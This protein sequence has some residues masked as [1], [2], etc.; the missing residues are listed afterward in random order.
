LDIG[1]GL[2]IPRLQ[3]GF[4]IKAAMELGMRVGPSQDLFELADLQVPQGL[5][6]EPFQKGVPLSV[7]CFFPVCHARAALSLIFHLMKRLFRLM[8]YPIPRVRIKQKN[9]IGGQKIRPGPAGPA[10]GYFS[11]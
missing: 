6:G 8:I 11:R 5:P 2:D 10:G 9:R 7:G 1:I 3:A 4:L